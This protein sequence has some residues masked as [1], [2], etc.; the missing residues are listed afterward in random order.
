MLGDKIVMLSGGKVECVGSPLFLKK[1]FD[2]GYSLTLVRT[3]A[4]SEA[5]STLPSWL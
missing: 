3:P 4:G 1:A 5:P 2:I